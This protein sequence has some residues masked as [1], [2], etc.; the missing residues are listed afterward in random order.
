[1]TRWI[2]AGALA[3]GLVHGAVA[4]EA[5]DGVAPEAATRL[6]PIVPDTLRPALRAKADGR[7]VDAPG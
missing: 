3:L 4:Q 6:G 5:A 7:P 1:M 2:V